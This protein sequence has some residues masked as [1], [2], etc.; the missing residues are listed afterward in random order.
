M[1][2]TKLHPKDK[3]GLGTESKNTLFSG[4]KLHVLQNQRFNLNQRLTN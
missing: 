4:Q 1:K 3:L 2:T